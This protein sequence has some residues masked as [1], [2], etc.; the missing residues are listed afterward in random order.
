MK[1]VVLSFMFL[2]L[3]NFSF[4][5]SLSP[6]LISSAGAYAAAGDITLS[7]S[8]GEI[9]VTTLTSDNL[10]LTQGFQQP[11]L[12]GTG[13]PDEMK[14]DWKVNAFPNPVQDRLNISIRLGKPVEMNLEI[15]DLTGKKILIKKLGRI[16]ADFDHSIDFSGF[17]KGIYFLKIQTT[18][19]K[20]S[21]IIKLQKQ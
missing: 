18:D 6:T 8:L 11:Q 14:L 17:V 16:P 20:Y 12:T 21:R 3:W 13:M 1:S 9:A 5:Q 15:I 2:I 7:Y 10:V 19:K 4:S